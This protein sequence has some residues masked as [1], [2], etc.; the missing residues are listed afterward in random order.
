[1][2]NLVRIK[3]DNDSDI[4]IIS[5]ITELEKNLINDITAIL[6]DNIYKDL[7]LEHVCKKMFYS[8]TYLNKLFNK[9]FKSSIMHYYSKLK[10]DES[11]VLLKDGLTITEISTKLC[12][13][14]PNYFSK[15]FKKHVGI[16]PTQFKESIR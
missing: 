11:K 6:K 14:N 7:S 12:F 4:K 9:Y 5:N 2:I 1:M 8:K 10:I 3:L 13:D 15:V 16:T